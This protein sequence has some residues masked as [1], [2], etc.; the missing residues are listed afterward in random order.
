MTS[1]LNNFFEFLEKLINSQD[2]LYEL[3]IVFMIIF[4]L[5][6]A[7]RV[8]KKL[9]FKKHNITLSNRMEIQNYFIHNCGNF[10]LYVDKTLT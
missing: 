1:F 4:A 6:V 9:H 7:F 3:C 2:A 5:E 8:Y 10:A